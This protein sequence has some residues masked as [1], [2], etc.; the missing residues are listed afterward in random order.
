MTLQDEHYPSPSRSHVNVV[1]ACFICGMIIKN[2]FL[3]DK[4]R[5]VSMNVY[6]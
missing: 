1:T 3:F 6:E 4:Y 5:Q 2:V